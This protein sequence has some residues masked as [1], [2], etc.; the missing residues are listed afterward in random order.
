MSTAPSQRIEELR[1]EARHA[2]ERCDLYRAKMYGM[3]PTS[4][5]RLRE[6]ERIQHGAEARLRDAEQQEAQP[7]TEARAADERPVPAESTTAAPD[8]R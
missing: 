4:A 3:R 1:A 7:Q 8:G 5:S 6:L 2:R